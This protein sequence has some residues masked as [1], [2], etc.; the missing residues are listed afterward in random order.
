MTSAISVF[1]TGLSKEL[2]N[3]E[4]DE[5]ELQVLKV[6]NKLSNIDCKMEA[7]LKTQFEENLLEEINEIKKI[8]R[9]M[10]SSDVHDLSCLFSSVL[11]K[12]IRSKTFTINLILF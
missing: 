7:E 5:W 8:L 2:S 1:E 6:I 12:W 4:I 9:K 11:P 10:T 3:S